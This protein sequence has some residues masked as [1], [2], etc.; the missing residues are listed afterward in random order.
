MSRLVRDRGEKL[1][2][3]LGELRRHFA[4]PGVF[5]NF[6]APNFG[7]PRETRSKT[8]YATQGGSEISAGRKK[9]NSVRMEAAN[10]VLWRSHETSA[11]QTA[12]LNRVEELVRTTPNPVIVLDLDDSLFSASTRQV[13]IWR[14]YGELHNIEQL[15]RMKA[16]DITS[17]D[18]K[19]LMVT[20]L[21]LDLKWFEEHFDELRAFWSERF[22]SN[23]Y[24]IKDAPLPGAAKYILA[25]HAAGVHIVYLSGRSEGE[26]G[27]GTREVLRRNGFPIGQERV[28]LILKDKS[29]KAI[30]QPGMSDGERIRA[31]READVRFKKEAIERVRTFGTVVAS[32]DNEPANINQYHDEFHNTGIGLAV[33]VDTYQAKDEPLREGVVVIQGFLR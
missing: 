4:K 30:W 16:G 8:V 19:T 9:A 28:T 1:S 15:K 10:P 7:A 21:G 31:Q 22:F 11:G 18:L 14:E 25:L 20:K 29:N 24:V 26:M 5:E 6:G 13:A 27:E 33:R 2:R 3:T 23:K 32:F 12:I 17:W